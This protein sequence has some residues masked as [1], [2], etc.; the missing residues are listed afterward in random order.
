MA[1]VG[2][3]ELKNGLSRYLK[4]VRRGEI[5]EV[6]DRGEPV[7]KIIPAGIPADIAE[8]I[9]EGK[10][11]WSG[12]RFVAPASPVRPKPG[13]PLASDIISEDRR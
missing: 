4:R 3:R 13:A 8:L 5:I 11:R 10:L 12:K 1:T 7:A 6:T 9:A 2:I